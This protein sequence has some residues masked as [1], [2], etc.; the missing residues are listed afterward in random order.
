MKFEMFSTP[1]KAHEFVPFLSLCPTNLL[2]KL[3]LWALSLGQLVFPHMHVCIQKSA[4]NYS[5]YHNT[6]R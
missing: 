6:H 3:C 5:S 4:Y 1:R 2:Q